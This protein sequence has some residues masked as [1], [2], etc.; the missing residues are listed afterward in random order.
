MSIDKGIPYKDRREALGN[1]MRTEIGEI[2]DRHK[3]FLRRQEKKMNYVII[4]TYSAGVFAGYLKN[5]NGKEVTLNQ[6]RRIYFWD[7]AATLSQ[8]ATDGTSKPDLCKFPCEIVGDHI[9]TEVIEIIPVTKKAQKSI[10][11]VKVWIA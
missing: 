9:L 5:L 3:T 10:E 8:L 11:S 6:S 4:R 1:P 7:G 2:L